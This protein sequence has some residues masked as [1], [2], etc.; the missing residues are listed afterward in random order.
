[1]VGNFID[2]IRFDLKKIPSNWNSG[3]RL[4]KTDYGNIRVLDTG[5][6]KPVIINTP[7]GPNV[8]EHHLKLI[9]E[10]S[11]N[12]RIICFELPGIGFSYPNFKYDYSLTKASKLIINLMDI[13]KVP[14]ATL[15][16][17]CSNGF[18]AIKTAELYPDRVNKLFLSQ[19]PS[20]HA[21]DEWVKKS[22]PNILKYPLI[23][24]VSNSFS[25]KKFAKMWYR[26]AL[27]KG[28]D[29]SEYQNIALNS[30]NTGGCFC[31]SGLV[32]GLKKDLNTSLK[33]LEVPST[34]IW[35]NM[36]Y[37][38]KKT[39]NESIL[40]HIPNCEIIE[41]GNCGHFPELEET[42]KYVKL[43]NERF[44]QPNT[45]TTQRKCILERIVFK[46]LP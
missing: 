43:I 16:F 42:N 46:I 45:T 35:G 38:H 9:K 6:N 4:T 37:T 28:T 2:N 19:T 40:E 17:S 20:L 14:R 11:K 32:Q 26:Y 22:I 29:V 13:L 30:L 3:A 24:Q 33:L 18:Y 1:M 7:D 12:F 31:L 36:D 10:L 25:E 23:G 15:A 34:L 5:G 21:M 8:I 44:R 39:N 27:P 41:F